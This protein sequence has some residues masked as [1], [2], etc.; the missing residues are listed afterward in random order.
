MH[1]RPAS[2]VCL[3]AVLTVAVAASAAIAGPTVT[4]N[5]GNTQSVDVAFA[6][7]KLSKT[8]ATPASLKV[9]TKTTSTTAANGVPSPAVRAVVDF[10]KSASLFT[11]GV[12]TCDPAKLQSTSTEAALQAC[13]KAKIGGG[14]GVALLPLGEKV[15]TEPTVITAFNGVP[16]GGRAVVLLHAY[17]SAP[18]QT[19]LVLV[20]RVSNFNKEGFG[21]RLDVEIPKIAGGTG[22]ITDF[23]VTINKKF[24]FKGLRRSYVSA[25]CPSSRK[26]KARA[27]FTYLDGESLTAVSKRSCQQR[28]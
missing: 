19:T 6:P 17:G 7:K 20:G 10:D 4:G 3:A 26:L 2:I 9:T 15:F 24:R 22:A 16:Q 11:K 5:D 28:S 27:T 1:R 25:K 18:V 23:T 12:P 8:K 14:G 21:P 13:G